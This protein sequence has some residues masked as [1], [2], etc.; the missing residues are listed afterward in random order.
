MKM[1]SV[2]VVSASC[3]DINSRDVHGRTM[4]YYASVKK[5]KTSLVTLIENGADVNIADNWGWTPLIQAA[6]MGMV[7]NC[8]T[9][10]TTPG[11]LLDYAAIDG[12]TALMH[13][14]ENG[15]SEVVQL[16]LDHGANINIKSTHGYTALIAAANTGR[17]DICKSLV[18]W[19]E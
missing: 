5:E 19:P 6:Q 9:L 12:R 2:K 1:V 15:H 13:A 8:R 11:C 17:Y 16:L 4:V 7:D 14:C 10:I 3:I 18:N